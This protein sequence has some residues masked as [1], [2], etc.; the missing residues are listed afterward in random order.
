MIRYRIGRH[1]VT[2]LLVSSAAAGAALPTRLP[3]PFERVPEP[4]RVVDLDGEYRE[5][6]WPAGE[7]RAR[8]LPLEEDG[9]LRLI[10]GEHF[11][12]PADNPAGYAI[13][14]EA[15]PTAT[16]VPNRE[17][18]EPAYAFVRSDAFEKGV[19]RLP[20]YP[21]GR[22]APEAIVRIR[23]VHPGERVWRSE[24]FA[25]PDAPRLSVDYGFPPDWE[26]AGEAPAIV[27]LYARALLADGETRELFSRA[28]SSDLFAD[29]WRTVELNLGELT[30]QT[31]RLELS[32]EPVETVPS[33]SFAAFWSVPR[34][35]SAA[36]ADDRPNVILVS[37]DTLRR[38]RLGFMGYERETSPRLDEFA[39]ECVVFEN[40]VAPSTWTTPSHGSMFTGAL[41][42]VH[43]AGM[44][45]K[46][47]VLADEWTTIAESARDAGYTTAAFTEGVAVS[48]RLGFA[49]GFERYSDGP[50]YT[51]RDRSG[52]SAVTFGA[53]S[54][55]ATRQ[56]AGPFFL[57]VHTFEIHAPYCSPPPEGH[58]FATDEAGASHCIYEQQIDSPKTGARASDL[59]DGGV[60]FT[61]HAFKR[62]LLD[63]LR[64]SGLLDNTIL[65]VTSDHGEE[66]NEHG[67]YGHTSH[68]YGEV[69]NVPLLIREP[70]AT[71]RRVSELVG[72]RD[73]YAT[74][75]DY[76]GVPADARY[77]DAQSLTGLV[78][79][80]KALGYR[81][82]HVYSFMPQR[83]AA[84]VMATG[85][86]HEYSHYAI[87]S[88]F[89]RY[90]MRD[91]EWLR[92][93]IEAGAADV[94]EWE[95]F[96]FDLKQ[97]PGEQQN[98]IASPPEFLID[99]KRALL[100]RLHEDHALKHLVEPSD[101]ESGAVSSE[102][103]EEI[104]AMGYF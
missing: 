76:L 7:T 35:A 98:L 60:L 41:P 102:A 37:L 57:F 61:D 6:V 79:G 94:P 14:V 93:Q 12:W 87:T 53:A 54:T 28:V 2:T 22:P 21:G 25:V 74:L 43:G 51:D 65:I 20:L 85:I 44:F 64:I 31:I 50:A 77:P 17:D 34:L 86:G 49:Q 4:Q 48:G 82:E 80:S 27:R 18:F 84:Q 19:A 33:R 83:D 59:Y 52:S 71:P 88:L 92:Q 67:G 58:A 39:E 89:G 45:H 81:R 1:I 95:E 5:V 99:L 24:P 13:R 38:D 101:S 56:A 75:A 40:A 100:E 16:P 91:R 42:W 47:F 66:F 104:E 23:L 36:I 30:G 70:G 9:A 68:I 62:L 72:T 90:M 73:L 97:D 55:W 29:A 11:V 69:I 15:R 32:A 3:I 10:A 103:V 78:R 63:R 26:A 46:N 96:A 8:R